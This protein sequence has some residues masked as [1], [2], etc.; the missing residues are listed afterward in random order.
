MTSAPLL[1]VIILFPLVLFIQLGFQCGPLYFT[2]EKLNKQPR[3]L[4]C[5]FVLTLA[6]G[7][8][9]VKVP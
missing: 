7:L 1:K 6:G 8:H 2:L 9:V 5:F 3:N 4:L